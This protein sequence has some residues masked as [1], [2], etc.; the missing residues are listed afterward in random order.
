MAGQPRKRLPKGQ[1]GAGEV[2]SEPGKSR[3]DRCN[4]GETR[5][6]D[7]MLEVTVDQQ[8]SGTEGVG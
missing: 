6:I 8:C 2:A 7:Q 5:E 4:D 3:V 1:V